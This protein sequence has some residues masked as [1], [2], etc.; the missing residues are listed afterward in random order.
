MVLSLGH[1]YPIP[2]HGLTRCIIPALQVG[3]QRRKEGGSLPQVVKTAKSGKRDLNLDLCLCGQISY[4]CFILLAGL[5]SSVLWNLLSI[6]PSGPRWVSSFLCAQPPCNTGRCG[7]LKTASGFGLDLGSWLQHSPY[8][9]TSDKV[10]NVPD[11]FPPLT[12]EHLERLNV[13]K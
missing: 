10:P 9:V 11:L 12:H 6:W 1:I 8:C 13:S 3:R 7:V 2:H 5:G 4:H